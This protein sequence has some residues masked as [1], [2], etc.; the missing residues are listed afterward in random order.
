M[1]KGSLKVITFNILV[2]F[3]L[4][5]FIEIILGKWRSSS[6]A[7]DIPFTI[8]NK[9]IKYDGS[10]IYG[11]GKNS[12]INYSR[13]NNGYRNFTNKNAKKYFL[14][15]GGSTTD[16]RYIPDGFTFQDLLEKK[17]GEN[18]AVINAGVDGQT[19]YGHLVSIRDWHSKLLDKKKLDKII[20]YFGVNDVRFTMFGVKRGQKEKWKSRSFFKKIRSSN[21]VQTI[22]KKSYFYYWLRRIKYKLT[23]NRSADGIQNVGHGTKNPEFIDE[24]EIKLFYK[25]NLDKIHEEY[26]NLVKDLVIETNRFF[27]NSELIFVQQPDNRCSFKDSRNVAP[28]AIKLG[29]MGYGKGLIDYCKYLGIVYLAQD[30]AFK[31]IKDSKVRSKIN[32]LKMYIDNPIP[33]EG[34]Y[35]GIHTN[36]IGSN[37][38]ANYLFE[39]IKLN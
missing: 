19:S 33:N 26:I 3:A 1:P 12:L 5:S 14:T 10:K 11:P 4:V 20:F 36:K 9:K 25:F 15:I 16:Q 37:Y 8:V 31:S 38:I 39:K 23:T 32:V 17:L 24:K 35:D 21:L 30:E 13:D 18:Y 22:S 7:Y 28:R 27:P 6:P 2:L 29:E 34:I